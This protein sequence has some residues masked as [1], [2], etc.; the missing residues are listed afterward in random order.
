M[1]YIC[2]EIL[3]TGERKKIHR[4]IFITT[5]R[6]GMLVTT[7]WVKAQGVGDGEQI[8]SLGT[9]EGYPR[10]KKITLA[11]YLEVK[12][13]EEVDPVATAQEALDILLGGNYEKK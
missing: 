7:H 13:A 4:P 6:N 12:G 11:E 1:D 2:I 10:A 9:L 8:W 3:E 5:N